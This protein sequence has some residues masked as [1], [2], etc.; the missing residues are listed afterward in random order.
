MYSDEHLYS[1]ALRKCSNIGD[2]TFS[3]LVTAIGSAKKVW[4]FPKRE[5]AKI[6]GIGSKTV[7]QI[8]SSDL[9]SFA[10]SEIKFCEKQLIKINLRHLGD[11]PELLDQCL[12][13]PSI[14]YQKGNYNHNLRSLSIVGTRNIT[15]YGKKFLED[16]FEE[17]KSEKFQ[18]VS[19]LALGVDAEV[20]QQSLK[21]NI[22]T[23]GILAHGFHTFY[24]SKNRKIADH[25]LQENGTLFSEFNSTQKPDRENFIQRNRII[26]GFSDTTIVVETAFGGG[27]ISTVNFANSYNRD[28]FALPGR[29]SDKY[30]QG[31]NRL[32]SQNKAATISTVKGLKEDLGFENN[33]TTA[34][35]FP[36]STYIQLTDF[37]KEIYD[38]LNKNTAISLDEISEK[39]DLLPYKILPI[40]LEL[41]LSGYIKTLSGKQYI[42]T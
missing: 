4:S 35:L 14:L 23:I 5:L 28:V 29:I 8:G 39:T 22:T 16:F 2:I 38:L 21:N 33:I 20:H 42:A 18:T 26:A 7:Q 37:Q 34:E 25:I 32:I 24:P 11:L 41:E 19:G 15:P 13:A 30:S 31:C 3:R 10:E 1:I 12:D 6:S 17:L 9:L 36:K 27:S 40:L